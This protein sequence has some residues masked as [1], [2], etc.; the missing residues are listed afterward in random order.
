[1][2]FE[3]AEAKVIAALPRW[4]AK[5]KGADLR[6]ESRGGVDVIDD[7]YLLAKA[8]GTNKIDFGYGDDGD[9]K[10]M[11]AVGD[12][13]CGTCGHGSVLIVRGII[14]VAAVG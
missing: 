14:D 6:L 5:S 4:T 13:G 11:V 8:L 10:A 12:W 3:E 7:A 1:M 2:T 9:E